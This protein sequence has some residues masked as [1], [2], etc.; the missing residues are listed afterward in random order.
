MTKSKI[1]RIL[2]HLVPFMAAKLS[3]VRSATPPPK[4]KL[5]DLTLRNS[6][7]SND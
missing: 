6:Y 5:W 4:K 7:D 3:E 1:V 2:K